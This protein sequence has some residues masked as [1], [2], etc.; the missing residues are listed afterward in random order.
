MT[1]R[2]RDTFSTIESAVPV[3]PAQL[4]ERK[5]IVVSHPDEAPRNE[6]V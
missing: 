2:I 3:S 5:R 6:Q 4:A 1:I